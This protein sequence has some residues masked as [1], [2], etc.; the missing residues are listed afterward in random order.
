MR[1]RLV[2]LAFAATA[3]VAACAPS[4]EPG[5]SYL[6]PDDSRVAAA[7]AEAQATLP[8]F[9]RLKDESPA[10]Y[11][12]FAVKVGLPTVEHDASEHIWVN[13]LRRDGDVV[14]GKLA[15]VPVD[16]GDLTVGSEVTFRPDMISDWQY[17]KDGLL[18][19]HFVTRAVMQGFSAREQAELSNILAPE[20]LEA[21]VQ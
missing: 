3:L 20:P 12:G 17:T 14:T 10:G 9:W 11:G 8:I 15:N 7:T 2:A 16:L 6:S 13:D 21:G 18:Y 19:G 1:G 5:F 4:E